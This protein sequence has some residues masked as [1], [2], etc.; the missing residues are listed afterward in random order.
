VG[1]LRLN[2]LVTLRLE[3]ELQ[4]QQKESNLPF[5]LITSRGGLVDRQKDNAWR[6]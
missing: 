5:A 3:T 4:V 6:F 2:S 1:F